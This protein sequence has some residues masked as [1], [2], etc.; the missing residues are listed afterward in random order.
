MG[1]IS[2]RQSDLILAVGV[3]LWAFGIVFLLLVLPDGNLVRITPIVLILLASSVVF[4][5]YR[6]AKRA[7]QA[8]QQLRNRLGIEGNGVPEGLDPLA[9]AAAAVGRLDRY[10]SEMETLTRAIRDARELQQRRLE[11]LSEVHRDL[12]THHR[13]TKKMLQSQRSEEVFET[14]RRGI[15]DGLGFRGVVLGIRDGEGHLVFRGDPDVEPPVRIPSWDERSFLAR[16]F[17]KGEQAMISEGMEAAPSGE[18]DRRV[19]NGRP[20]FVLPVLRKQNRKCA[21]L[22]N[23]GETGCPA[24]FGNSQQCWTTGALYCLPSPEL[25]AAERRRL[26]ALCEMFSPAGLVIARTVPGS[27]RV[28]PETVGSIMTL[29]N[30]A[31][32]ALEA[33]DLYENLKRMSVTDGLTGLINYREFYHLLRNELER[34][35]R[36]NSSIS[37]LIIDVDDF[38]RFNDRFGH[39]AG[40]RALKEIAGLLRRCSRGSDIVARYGGEEFAIILPESTPAGA[41]MMAERIK[42]DVGNHDFQ[43]GV[44]E[45]VCLTVSIGIYFSETGAHSEDQLVSCADEAA[46]RAKFM[47]KNRVVIKTDA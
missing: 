25:S 3:L 19:L 29:A 47:G 7:E 12:L 30:E 18:E 38:K 14:L 5:Q 35:R 17:W 40:D 16:T 44:G 37:L 46:Y 32:L 31:S 15:R 20:A 39:L 13:F 11:E 2:V 42:T 45:S 6:I 8:A 22:R 9:A 27:R 33:V 28:T 10:E 1:K 21:D 24:F 36:Y 26:C 4:V 43:P 23:C 34:A 41:L